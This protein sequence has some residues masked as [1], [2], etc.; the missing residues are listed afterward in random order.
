MKNRCFA[1]LFYRV[2]VAL[3]FT[4]AFNGIAQAAPPTPADP[5]RRVTCEECPC[6]SVGWCYVSLPAETDEDEDVCCQNGI[7]QE[8]TY[9]WEQCLLIPSPEPERPPGVECSSFGFWCVKGSN[10]RPTEERCSERTI[11]FPSP[12]EDEDN[13]GTA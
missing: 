11:L 10:S 8:V 1:Q 2:V 7:M 3:A 6:T 9:Y 13:G 4:L 5:C 12:C